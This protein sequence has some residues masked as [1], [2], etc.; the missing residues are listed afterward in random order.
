MNGPSSTAVRLVQLYAGLL[1]FGVSLALFLASDLGSAPWDVLHQGLSRTV[2]LSIGAWN[3]LLGVAVLLLW[4]PLR[5]RPGLGTVSNVAV[6]GVTIDATLAVLPELQGLPARVALVVAGVVL[7]AVGSAAYIGAG[8]GPGPRDGLMTG[9]AERTGHGVGLVRTGI[10]L[11]VL[12]LGVLLGGVVGVGT[13]VYALGIGPLVQPL[14]PLL[15]RRPPRPV[16][17]GVVAR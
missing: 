15:D 12:V 4:V 10:E 6:L 3:V 5:Q 16:G 11:T 13:V 8:F 7:G 17:A 9:L 2:G 14:L 1:L